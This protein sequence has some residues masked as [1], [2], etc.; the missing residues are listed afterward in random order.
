MLTHNI[1]LQGRAEQSMGEGAGVQRAAK[2]CG[3]PPSAPACPASGHQPPRAGLAP[4][5]T[6]VPVRAAHLHTR[7]LPHHH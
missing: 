1:A 7:P 6:P 5:H 2:P 4:V 3:P